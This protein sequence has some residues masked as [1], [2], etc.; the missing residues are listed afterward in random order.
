[1]K[2]CTEFAL[3][4]SVVIVDHCAFQ[5]AYMCLLFGLQLVSDEEFNVKMFHFNHV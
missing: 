1:M 3:Q 5:L 2:G 4:L